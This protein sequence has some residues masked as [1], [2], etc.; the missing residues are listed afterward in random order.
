MATRLEET[1]TLI[2][3]LESL[4]NQ[5]RPIAHRAT[6]LFA[7]IKSM[8]VVKREYQFTLTY[9][10]SLFDEAISQYAMVGLSL[11]CKLVYF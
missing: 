2:S 3:R 8:C 10:L 9:F 6:L 7:V 11:N 4:R 5:L 1:I